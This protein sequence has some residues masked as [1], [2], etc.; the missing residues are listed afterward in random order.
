[1]AGKV[2]KMNEYELNKRQCKNEQKCENPATAHT[3]DR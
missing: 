3:L 2:L 1:M